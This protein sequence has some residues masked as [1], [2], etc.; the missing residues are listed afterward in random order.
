MT[1]LGNR[2]GCGD[3]ASEAT[4]LLHSVAEPGGTA[5]AHPGA[6]VNSEEE[7][8]KAGT[9]RVQPLSLFSEKC[10]RVCGVMES[11]T[12]GGRDVQSPSRVGL[13]YV[14]CGDSKLKRESSGVLKRGTDLFG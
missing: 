7:Q 10:G 2:V 5:V 3:Q 4:E 9:G 13:G 6:S 14:L 8:T 11:R 1:A 12:L